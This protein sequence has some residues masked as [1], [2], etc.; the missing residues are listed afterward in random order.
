MEQYK[1]MQ[2]YKR[3]NYHDDIVL[4]TPTVSIG[5]RMLDIFLK[6]QSYDGNIILEFKYPNY[7]KDIQDIMKD[8]CLNA[9]RNIL[10]IETE[11]SLNDL[12]G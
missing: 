4:M 2:S 11:R 9:G 6:N 5:E 10:A 7:Q 1:F 8:L 12:L 3:I